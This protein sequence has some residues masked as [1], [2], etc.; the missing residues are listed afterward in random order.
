MLIFAWSGFPQ[1]AARCIG[2]L[3]KSM[4][5]PVLVVAT[6]PAV[7]VEGMG[8][9]CNCPIVWIDGSTL[10]PFNLSTI[11]PFTSLTLFVSGW[12]VP[13]FNELRDQVRAAGGQV[14]C[15]NDGNY[16]GLKS[17]KVE[18]LKGLGWGGWLK[19]LARAVV[20]RLKYRKLFDGYLVPGK[21][22]RRLMRF[23]GVPDEKIAEGMYSADESLFDPAKVEVTK[24]EK[25]IVYVGQYIDRKNVLAVCQAFEESG[26]AADGWT[27]EM[28]GSGPLKDQLPYAQPFVQ[29]EQLP[30]IYRRAKAFILASKEEHWG[31]VVHEAALSGCYLMLSNRVGAAEDLLGEKN[32]VEFDPFRQEEMTAAFRRLAAMDESAFAAAARVSMELGRQRG[33]G[34]FVAGVNRLRR[35]GE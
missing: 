15:M 9:V 13:A 29:P 17:C 14:I 31:L 1:Y 6:R 25:R 8:K 21:S 18:R 28:Y 3:A 12:T 32:G 24:K 19:Q 5:E 16:L 34:S 30:A 35:E 33:L 11:Q 20:F 4:S 23:Y 10:Q 2:A 27:L 26:I 22:G 7:P